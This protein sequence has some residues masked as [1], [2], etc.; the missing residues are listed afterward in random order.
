MKSSNK[1]DHVEFLGFLYFLLLLFFFKCAFV[2][3][4]KADLSQGDAVNSGSG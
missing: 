2:N 3:S 4:G 1:E